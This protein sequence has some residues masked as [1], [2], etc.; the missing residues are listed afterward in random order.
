MRPLVAVL[1]CCQVLLSSAAKGDQSFPY[2]TLVVTD[3]VYVRSG[4]GQNYYP[5]DKL[6][7]GQE[8]EVYRHDPGGWCAIRPV[9]GSFTWV[10]SR[11]LKPTED[12]LAVVTDDGVSARVGSRFS[13]VRDVVQVRLQ[14]G[15]VVELLDPPPR[16][17]GRSEN[18]WLKIAP[19]SGEFRWV[20]SKYLDADYP[21]E[22]VR[23]APAARKQSHRHGDEETADVSNGSSAPIIPAAALAGSEAAEAAREPHH[24]R[25][26]RPRSLSAEEFRAELDRIELELSVMVIEEPAVWSFESLRER[27][28]VLLDQAQTAVERGRARLLANKIA[29][30]DDIKQRQDAVLAMREQTDRTSRLLTSLQPKDAGPARGGRPGSRRTA[31]STASGS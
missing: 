25:L 14:K 30:F 21:R 28:N 20:S 22:G 2:K 17:Q 18:V 1:L 16:G 12:H 7:R 19:P 3:D 29:R 10:S 8:V 27:T 13:D 23:V 15:E 31:A 26:A 4:P 9:D 11:Y 5:T 24:E 6:K